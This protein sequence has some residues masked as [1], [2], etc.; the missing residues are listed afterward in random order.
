MEAQRVLTGGEKDAKTGKR[1]R[2]G[3]FVLETSAL[4]WC[5]EN[6]LNRL[7]TARYTFKSTTVMHVILDGSN[8]FKKK[9]L[10][11]ISFDPATGRAFFCPQQAEPCLL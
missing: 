9:L 11:V 4:A 8:L 7:T 1:K 3:A 2:G 6:G 10:V 5:R